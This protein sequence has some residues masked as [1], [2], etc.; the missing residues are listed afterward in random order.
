MT[1][2]EH[3]TNSQKATRIIQSICINHSGKNLYS[4]KAERND[5]HRCTINL[6]PT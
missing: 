3:T 6:L 5:L 4:E 2:M 1:N